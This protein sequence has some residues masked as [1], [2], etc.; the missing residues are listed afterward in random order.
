MGPLCNGKGPGHTEPNGAF[1]EESPLQQHLNAVADQEAQGA[2]VKLQAAH[3]G[4]R[5]VLTLR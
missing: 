2:V 4:V 3:L 1:C 5:A